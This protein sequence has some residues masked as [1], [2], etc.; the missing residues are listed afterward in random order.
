MENY[1]REILKTGINDL[2]FKGIYL[3]DF[4][5]THGICNLEGLLL[6]RFN[7]Y[8]TYEQL[9]D[10]SSHLSCSEIRRINKVIKS[11]GV[12]ELHLGMSK[13]EIEKVVEE[14]ERHPV[15]FSK[16]RRVERI[17]KSKKRLKTKQETLKLRKQWALEEL[18]KVSKE[19]ERLRRKSV[20]LDAKI[21]LLSINLGLENGDDN[22]RA[23]Q[24]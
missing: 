11:F 15:F 12:P 22:G 7:T 18:E 3:A 16:D 21:A 10:R 4:L 19:Q 24:L 8:G 17:R 2:D 5:S 13:A 9:T 1:V 14:Y 20:E 23:K 6:S